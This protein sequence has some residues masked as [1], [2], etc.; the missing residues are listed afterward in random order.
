MSREH[1]KEEEEEGRQA[2]REPAD[3]TILAPRD[4]AAAV[5]K[6]NWSRVY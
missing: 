4:V 5:I 2:G 3:E 1:E 6:E